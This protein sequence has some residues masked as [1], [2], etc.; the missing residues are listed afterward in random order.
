SA[1][2][3]NA[4]D[5]KNSAQQTAASPQNTDDSAPG[6]Q[7]DQGRQTATT[8]PAGDHTARVPEQNTPDGPGD[9]P[10]RPDPLPATATR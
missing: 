6:H 5:S 7:A 9:A 4:E 8:D 10:S 3:K 1:K 2:S